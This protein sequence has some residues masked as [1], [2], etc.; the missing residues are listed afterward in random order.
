MPV[1]VDPRSRMM[2]GTGDRLGPPLMARPLYAVLANPGIHVPTPAVFARMGFQPGE[3]RDLGD[4]PVPHDDLSHAE[5]LALVGAGRN[6]MEA[7]A[8][9]LAPEIGDAI[10]ALSAT[11]GHR[12]VR[13]SGSG[14]TCFALYDDRRRARAA[15]QLLAGARPDWWIRATALR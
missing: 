10:D 6:D 4:H 7:A 9:S 11:P 12:T 5:F 13:M 8:L 1:C 14:S 2:A 3:S 15:A